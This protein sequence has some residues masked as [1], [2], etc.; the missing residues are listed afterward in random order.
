M[1][2]QRRRNRILPWVI[3]PLVIICFFWLLV[4]LSNILTPF[5][6]AAIL[7]YMLNP[8]VTKLTNKGVKRSPA[9]MLVMLICFLVMLLLFLI[10]VPMLV[11]QIDALFN[12]IPSLLSFV[13]EKVLPW[14]NTKF[15]RSY[16]LDGQTLSQ[17][18]QDN[19]NGIR[20]AL[21]KA[22]PSIAQ[23]GGRMI[24]V[25]VNLFLLPF[26]LYY[27][28]L[29]WQKWQDSIAKMMP[30]RWISKVTAV[31]HEL[32]N[33]L[34]EF[35][36]GQ[37]TVMMSMG[38]IYGI[39]LSLTGLN[40]GFAIG[41]LAGL[42]GF[43]PYLGAFIGFALATI[44]ALLQFDSFIPLL[45]VWGIFGAGLMFEGYIL[46]PRLVG[47]RIGLSPMAVIFALMA[48][49]ELM[50]FVGMLL[51]LPL[52]AIVLVLARE[53]L[54]IYYETHF[55]RTVRKK[56]PILHQGPPLTEDKDQ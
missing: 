46:T 56:I 41:M 51:A 5:V 19:A 42:V 48:F 23:G 21:Q 4:G 34:G 52:A 55:Y 24:G 28:L 22:V 39:G 37:L 50:G 6:F 13:Q 14:V 35:L 49:G 27:F 38:F 18:F 25:F 2:Q 16:S 7:G 1:Y 31:A 9:A 36:R 33:V 12:H 8:L 40:S 26:L 3:V 20:V 53:I 54:K 47:E 43:V 45:I 44:A 10:V 17:L 30:R 29:D 15:K 11:S 32:D